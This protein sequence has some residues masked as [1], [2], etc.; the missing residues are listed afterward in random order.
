L[1]ESVFQALVLVQI[2]RR[3]LHYQQLDQ[4]AMTIRDLRSLLH[5]MAPMVLKNSET[6]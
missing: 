3:H 5:R 4:A 2:T 6:D 1:L